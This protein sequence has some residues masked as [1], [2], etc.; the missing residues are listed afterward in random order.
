M[1]APPLLLAV[2]ADLVVHG[3]GFNLA[4]V[5]IPAPPPLT[6]W[7]STNDLVGMESGELEELLAVAASAIAHQENLDVIWIARWTTRQEY[8]TRE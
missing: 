4:A 2:P 3:I 5:I 7:A 8:N 1:A 6:V